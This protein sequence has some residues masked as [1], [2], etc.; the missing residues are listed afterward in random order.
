VTPVMTAIT[1]TSHSTYR[2]NVACH[3]PLLLGTGKHMIF[4]RVATLH[5]LF[6]NITLYFIHKTTSAE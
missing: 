4:V 3:S 5:S 1:M 6:T 2:C